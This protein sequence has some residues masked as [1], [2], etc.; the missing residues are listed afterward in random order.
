[1]I[2][3]LWDPLYDKYR[4][5]RIYRYIKEVVICKLQETLLK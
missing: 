1:M 5:V 2:P 3:A 4:I